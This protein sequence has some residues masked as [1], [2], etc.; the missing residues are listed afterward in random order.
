M[1]KLTMVLESCSMRFLFGLIVAVELVVATASSAQDV[2]WRA[3]SALLELGMTEQQVVNKVGQAPSKVE[4]E[5]CVETWRGT[6][7]IHTYGSVY[8]NHLKVVFSQTDDRV[9]RADSWRVYR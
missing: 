1:L 8:G 7:K 3:K 4:M 5:T 9:W 6:C 2:N